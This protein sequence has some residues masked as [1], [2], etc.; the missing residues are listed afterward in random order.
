MADLT[1][2]VDVPAPA[3]TETSHIIAW[4]NRTNTYRPAYSVHLAIYVSSQ[5]YY[6]V[7]HEINSSYEVEV[8]TG[9]YALHMTR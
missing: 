4:D 6:A 7:L 9:M 1:F 3:S 5:D 8:R 2:R